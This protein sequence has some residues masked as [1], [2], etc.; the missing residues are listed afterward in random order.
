MSE[1]VRPVYARGFFSFSADGRVNQLVVFYYYDPEAY[2]VGLSKEELSEEIN[3]L[4]ENMQRFLD[5]EKIMINGKMVRARV[6][7]VRI[8]FVSINYPFIEYV[9]DFKGNLVK[10]ENVYENEY[11]NEI[12][13]YPY[14]AIWVFPGPITSYRLA[15]K[16]SV[17][18]NLLELEVLPGT[19]TGGLEWIRFKL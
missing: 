19:E 16:V 6:R 3:V 18:E 2:Y 13:E 17:L 5:D 15:G 14:E 12:T 11:E 1:K 8:G 4:K 7:H 9:I 10:G